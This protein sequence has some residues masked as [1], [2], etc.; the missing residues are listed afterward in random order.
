[1]ESITFDFIFVTLADRCRS[2]TAGHM[3]VGGTV[4]LENFPRLHSILTL[5]AHRLCN[6]ILHHRHVSPEY[7]LIL[8]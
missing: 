5:L 4:K 2:S 7:A 6:V 3:A 1:M 8:L